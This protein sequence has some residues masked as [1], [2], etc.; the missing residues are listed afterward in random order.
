M[1]TTLVVMPTATRYHDGGKYA[2]TIL[3]SSVGDL[4]SV[5]AARGIL[6]SF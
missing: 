2:R 6:S 5:S 1:S 3:C 4:S